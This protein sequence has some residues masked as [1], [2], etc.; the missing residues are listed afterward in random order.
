MAEKGTATP[1]AVRTESE[2]EMT[3]AEM[4]R[5]AQ[6]LLRAEKGSVAQAKVVARKIDPKGRQAD[7][8]KNAFGIAASASKA[9]AVSRAIISH[10]RGGRKR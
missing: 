4:V 9:T 6:Q 7:R 5:A 1:N 3:P 2:A 10:A 8:R